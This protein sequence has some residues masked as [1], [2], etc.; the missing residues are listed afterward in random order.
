MF[1]WEI[2]PTINYVDWL[3]VNQFI[4]LFHMKVN[5]MKKSITLKKSE[6]TL[7]NENEIRDLIHIHTSLG[8]RSSSIFHSTEK[9]MLRYY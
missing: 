9:R 1:I 7:L 3:D 4:N 5:E 2:K 6:L 8:F